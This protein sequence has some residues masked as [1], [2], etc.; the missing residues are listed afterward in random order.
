MLS[1]IPLRWVAIAVF[2]LANSLSYLDRQLLSAVGPTLR[3]EF[4]LSNADFGLIVLAFYLTYSLAAPA[5][6]LWLDRAGLNKGITL[7]LGAWSII[8]IVTGS[9][10]GLVSLLSC[11]AALGVAEA[12]TIPAHGKAVGLYLHAGERALGT[13]SGQLGISL[14]SAGAVFLAGLLAPDYGWRPVFAV[15]GALGFFWI[16]LW[17]YVSRRIPHQPLPPAPEQRLSR[18][19]RLWGLIPAAMLGMAVYSTWTNW[20]TMFLSQRHGL[21]EQQA[22]LSF[23]WLPPLMFTAGGLSGGALSMWLAR[24]AASIVQARLRA[25]LVSATAQI[26]TAGVPYLPSPELATAAICWSGFWAAALSV[27]LYALPVDMFGP[28]RAGSGVAALT[29]S[30]GLMTA[31]LSWGSGALI[32]RAGWVPV[33]AIVAFMPLACYAILRAASRAS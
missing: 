1:Q 32:D 9:T 6:G 8:G 2:G 28:Q 25:I 19:P 16:P 13:A 31:G 20:T 10:A 18:D 27:N 30:Y 33:C 5:A 23:A 22:N 7:S 29:F 14:G 3:K 24:G 11:R 4:Q 12:T 17:L 21:A 26:V 15:A